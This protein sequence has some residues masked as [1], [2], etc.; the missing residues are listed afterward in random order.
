[1]VVLGLLI[2]FFA[3]LCPLQISAQIPLVMPKSDTIEEIPILAEILQDCKLYS[4]KSLNFPILELF[5]G[6]QAEILEDYSMKQYRIKINESLETTGWIDGANLGIPPDAPTNP[7]PLSQ[8]F[9]E[10]F[11]NERGY[12][13]K[14]DFLI[15]TDISRQQTHVFLKSQEQNWK[16]MRSLSCST[17][18]NISPTTRGEFQIADRGL[19]FYSERLESGAKYWMRFNGDYL[20]HSIPMN[21][22]CEIIEDE[23]TVGI[24]RS[25]GC[26]R[27]LVDDAKWLYDNVPDKTTVIII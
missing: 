16:H 1:M 26:V 7:I 19:W 22:Q 20:F 4:D 3:L 14:T 24:R 21:S 10:C 18:M 17:G 12:T 15:L 5:A 25:N 11:V 13:S 2:L 9:L 27:L 8:D 23:N 6:M